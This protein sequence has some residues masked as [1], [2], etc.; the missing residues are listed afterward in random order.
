MDTI[1]SVGPGLAA[2]IIGLYLLLI[3]ILKLKNRYFKI[4]FIKETFE[5]PK[6]W[7][8]R[9]LVALIGIGLMAF[10][11]L[12]I[13]RYGHLVLV[14]TETPVPAEA[15]AEIEPTEIPVATE[16]PIPMI[17]ITGDET[18]EEE[19]PPA[20]QIQVLYED[21]FLDNHNDW[22][23]Q[24]NA[25]GKSYFLGGQ[26]IHKL[27]CSG[28]DSEEF[29]FCSTIIR[30]PAFTGKNYR[31][32]F[33]SS[34]E[35]SSPA[36]VAGVGII[37]RQTDNANYYFGYRTNGLYSVY[38]LSHNSYSYFVE[39]QPMSG[40]LS[41][42]GITNRYGAIINDTNLTA[43]VNG[44][45]LSAFEDGNINVPGDAKLVLLVSKGGTATFK[46]DNLIITTP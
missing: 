31:I 6:A 29:Y 34:I 3:I 8:Q 7:W 27:S 46:L 14:T 21:T 4:P 42:I 20:P 39:N 22:L 5:L 24:E 41:E 17:N 40:Y 1:Q 16:M 23:V 25:Q 44:V 30:I 35:P 12:F 45:E 15:L 43:L 11:C 13:A 28:A 37:V 18:V 38:L 26:Y 32:E 36:D 10:G 2:F 33:D 9:T 19:I